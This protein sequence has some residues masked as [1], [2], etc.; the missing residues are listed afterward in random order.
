MQADFRTSSVCFPLQKKSGTRKKI[1]KK[2]IKEDISQKQCGST[3]KLNQDDQ[4]RRIR[5]RDT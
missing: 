4:L 5:P 3:N 2:K 1:N